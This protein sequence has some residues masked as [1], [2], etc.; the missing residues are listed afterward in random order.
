ML[1]ST[2]FLSTLLVI[3]AGCQPPAEHQEDANS[4]TAPA[5]ASVEALEAPTFDVSLLLGRWVLPLDP[6]T[7]YQPWKFFDIQ[8]YYGDGNEEG[9]YFELAG[10]QLTY[11]AEHGRVTH[12]VIVLSE[13]QLIEETEEGMRLEWHKADL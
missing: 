5:S 1:K 6:E 3:L 11:Y 10:D 8:K 4:N 9:A 2:L 7:G 13:S 12:T